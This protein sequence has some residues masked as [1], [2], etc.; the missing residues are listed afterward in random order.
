MHLFE[1]V[2]RLQH[3]DAAGVVF[4]ARFF[5]L[6]HLAYEDM[7]DA[8]GHPLSRDLARADPILPVVHASSDCRAALMLGDRV[9][10][11]V[12]VREVRSRSFRL[13]YRFTKPDGSDVA[14]LETVHIAVDATTRKATR[15]P[16]ALAEAL[17]GVADRAGM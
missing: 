5:D 7:L 11:E 17:R 13:G 16:E 14:G 1:T 9:R 12:D 15:L 2:V 8:V 3:T 10:I 4:F 6:A